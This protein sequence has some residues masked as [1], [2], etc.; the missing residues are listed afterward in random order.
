MNGRKVLDEVKNPA[1]AKWAETFVDPVVKGL[2]PQTDKLIEFAKALI[3][4]MLQSKWNYISCKMTW[5][6]EVV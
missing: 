2:L 4:N 1:L 3:K 6:F 5:N